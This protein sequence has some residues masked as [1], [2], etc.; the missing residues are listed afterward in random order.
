M[1]TLVT[2]GAG[3]IGSNLVDALLA[4]G[5]EVHVLDDLS[6]GNRERVAGAATLLALAWQ[7]WRIGG[8]NPHPNPSNHVRVHAR[9]Q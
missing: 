8:A 5:D 9:Q 2:G 7:W 4:R 3:F 6:K 1:R